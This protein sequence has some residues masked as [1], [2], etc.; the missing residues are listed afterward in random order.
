MVTIVHS[1]W[2]Q[3]LTEQKIVPGSTATAF[4]I[5]CY[6]YREFNLLCD[7]VD[8]GTTAAGVVAGTWIVGQ[9]SAA[10]AIVIS[11]TLNSGAWGNASTENIGAGANLDH[12][13]VRANT[14]AKMCMDEYMHRGEMAKAVEIICQ[15]NTNLFSVSGATPDQTS[16][17]GIV[18]PAASSIMIQDINDIKNFKCIDYTNLSAS[19]IQAQFWF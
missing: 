11:A 4:S 18:L 12:L 1:T 7:G 15:T 19:V 14:A 3:C 8:A 6:Q 10:R 13:T 2:G 5:H 17:I 9:T 16:L